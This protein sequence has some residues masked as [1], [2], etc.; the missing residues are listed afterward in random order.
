M[1]QSLVILRDY[2]RHYQRTDREGRLVTT[3]SN[4]IASPPAADHLLEVA[5]T[6]RVFADRMPALQESARLLAGLELRVDS[7]EAVAEKIRESRLGEAV[8]GFDR[9]EHVASNLRDASISL[10]SLAGTVQSM[11]RTA[12][13]LA[14]AALTVPVRSGWSWR[15]FMWGVGTVAAILLTVLVIRAL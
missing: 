3:T 14:Y 1:R 11:E 7:L 8:T 6:L 12:E 9:V 5:Q 10:Q 2:R 15:S 4:A 13:N